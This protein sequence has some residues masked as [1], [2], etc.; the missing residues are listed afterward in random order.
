MRLEIGG[1][2]RGARHA[3]GLRLSDVARA[4]GRSEPWL[5][6][7]ERGTDS[8]VSIDEMVLLSAAVGL[9]L[10]ITQYPAARALRDAPQ[11]DL[12][13]RFRARVGEL[14]TWS[15]E[16][17]VPIPRDQRAA[18]AVIRRNLTVIMIEAFTRL[19][20]AQSQL[21][22]VLLKARDMGIG[23]V[24]VVVAAT[25]TN[26]QALAAAAQLVAAEFPLGTRASLNAL[27]QGRDPGANGIVLI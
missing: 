1:A 16:V 12:L 11:L 14:W 22:A 3:A 17:I 10:W 25:P 8:T 7:V 15:Y 21:R 6:R 23:R 9:K 20:D 2:I 13:R 27:A 18:D 4:I 5:S 26:R 19:S 24:I